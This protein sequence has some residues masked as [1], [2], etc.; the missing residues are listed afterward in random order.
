MPLQLFVCHFN[1]HVA[2]CEEKQISSSEVQVQ[3]RSFLSP[4]W[5]FH[6]SSHSWRNPFISREN[7]LTEIRRVSAMLD[8]RFLHTTVPEGTGVIQT[9]YL[10]RYRYW[11]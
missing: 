11:M 2:L 10:G 4:D 3:L 7:A 9:C 8:Q 5:T 1:L 6:P